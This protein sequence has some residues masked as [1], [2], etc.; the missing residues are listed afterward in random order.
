MV[1]VGCGVLLALATIYFRVY[2]SPDGLRCY[3]FNGIYQTARWEAITEVIPFNFFGL[4]YLRVFSSDTKRP[5][6][7][8]LFLSDMP[9]F[10]A[11]VVRFAGVEHPLAKALTKA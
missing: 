3:D 7:V 10:T 4:R 2:L 1:V 6:Y 8:P 9:G 11:E 5:R